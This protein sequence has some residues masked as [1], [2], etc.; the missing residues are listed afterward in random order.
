MTYRDGTTDP[1][2][3]HTER[4]LREHLDRAQ[5]ERGQ[6]QRTVSAIDSMD[7]PTLEPEWLVHERHLMFSLVND[8]RAQRGHAPVRLRNIRVIEDSLVGR[9]DRS[10]RLVEALARLVH[11]LPNR[12]R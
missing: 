12:S 11:N 5:A 7:R 10:E 9:V 4:R 1:A 2:L 8:Y 3:R 6:R